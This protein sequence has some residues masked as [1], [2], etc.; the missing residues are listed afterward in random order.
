[1]H[2]SNVSPKMISLSK[3]SSRDTQSKSTIV[4]IATTEETQAS[5]DWFAE[6]ASG[7]RYG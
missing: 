1:M 5:D 4:N 3:P 2:V 7:Q 6:K